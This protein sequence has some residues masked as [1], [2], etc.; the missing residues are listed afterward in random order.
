MVD[1]NK[2]SSWVAA[3]T[4]LLTASA[5][6][7]AERVKNEYPPNIILIVEDGE[8]SLLLRNI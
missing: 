8:L 1:F 4:L 5:C 2:C 6:H 7:N 3:G